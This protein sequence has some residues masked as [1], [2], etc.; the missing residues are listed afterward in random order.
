MTFELWLWTLPCHEPFFDMTFTFLKDLLSG[1]DH[2]V[3]NKKLIIIQSICLA[4]AFDLG[5]SGILWHLYLH[6]VFSYYTRSMMMMM[7]VPSCH[8]LHQRALFKLCSLL[9]FFL[10]FIKSLSQISIN[11][12]SFTYFRKIYFESLLSSRILSWT[13]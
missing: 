10:V 4:L 11:L 7:I 2:I 6:R 5:V 1:N 13:P 9:F 3:L 8:R 12:K